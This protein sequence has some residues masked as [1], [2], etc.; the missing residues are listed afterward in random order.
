MIDLND[1]HFKNSD[2]IIKVVDVINPLYSVRTEECPIGTSVCL[3]NINEFVGKVYF[4]PLRIQLLDEQLE[5]CKKYVNYIKSLTYTTPYKFNCFTD[6]YYLIGC[7]FLD[8]DII[9][10]GNNIFHFIDL[11]FDLPCNKDKTDLFI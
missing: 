4:K 10:E 3:K 2:T 9:I 8:I 11:Y 5:S 6:K 1:V 7:M